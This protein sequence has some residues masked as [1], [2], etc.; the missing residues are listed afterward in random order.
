[1]VRFVLITANPTKARWIMFANNRVRVRHPHDQSN[2][3]RTKP[4]GVFHIEGTGMTSQDLTAVALTT[5]A[6]PPL[7]GHLYVFPRSN[8]TK[9]RVTI[10]FLHA[11]D[12]GANP[13]QQHSHPPLDESDPTPDTL[14]IT[15]NDPNPDTSTVP[16]DLVN[17]DPCGSPD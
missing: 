12:T 16:V 7:R 6:Q 9:G 2:P 5:V 17:T 3:D 10:H 8:G 14:T 4:L 11:F 15:I 1:M 13:K